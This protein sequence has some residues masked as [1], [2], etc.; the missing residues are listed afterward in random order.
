MKKKKQTNKQNK[1]NKNQKQKYL[2][3]KEK[4]Q[5]VTWDTFLSK[6]CL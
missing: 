1:Q 5:S 6:L 2:N 4:T 3:M